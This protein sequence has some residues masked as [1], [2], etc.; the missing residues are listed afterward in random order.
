MLLLAFLCALVVFTILMAVMV[1]KWA[2]GY[3]QRPYATRRPVRE[4]AGGGTSAA[5]SQRERLFMTNK[6][7]RIYPIDA[8]GMPM[9]KRV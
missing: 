3:I 7:P 5:L 9:S 6:G 2:N 4:G 1:L 8:N